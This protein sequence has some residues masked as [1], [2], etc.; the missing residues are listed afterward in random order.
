MRIKV[1]ILP[2]LSN[3][4]RP[5]HIGSIRFE[6]ELAGSSFRDLLDELAR[7]DA[8]F[9]ELIYDPQSG[10]MKYPAQGIVNGKLL[11]FLGGL[12]AR[13]SAGDTATFIA[14]YTGG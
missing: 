8:A 13:L 10:D 11:E 4:M 1:E 6:H 2:W 3:S 14:T 5:G 12:D 9:A 7:D